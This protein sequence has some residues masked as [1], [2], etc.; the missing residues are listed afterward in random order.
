MTLG[1]QLTLDGQEVEIPVIQTA[2]SPLTGAQREI[3][4]LARRQGQVR[5]REAGQIV[6]LHRMPQCGWCMREKCGFASIDGS[7]A[8]KRL[9]KRGFLR[10]IA[11]GL[12][13]PREAG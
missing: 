8:L 5:S 9:A 7:D 4:E 10:R 6:H 3:L 13:I 1:L 12:W 11:P 2:R